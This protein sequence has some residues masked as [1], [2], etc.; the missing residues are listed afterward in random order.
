MNPIKAATLAVCLLLL[1]QAGCSSRS[2]D[3][4]QLIGTVRSDGSSTVFLLTEA[5]AEEFGHLHPRVRVSVGTSGTGGGFKKL[6]AGEIDL[7]NASRKI[8]DAERDACVAAGIEPIE[9][10]VAFDGLSVVVN[11]KNDWVES[12]T[13][14]QL[15][16]IWRP[17]S[18]IKKW[19]DLNPAWPDHDIHLFGP[20]TDSGT[21]DYFT[22]AICG[23]VGAS[24]SDYTASE[25]DNTLVTGVERDLYA[26]GYFGFAYYNQNREH[27]KLIPIDGGQGPVAP[28][29]ATI[30]DGTYRPLSRPLLTYVKKTS[31]ERPEIAAFVEFYLQQAATLS[32]EVGYVPLADATLSEQ[33]ATLKAQLGPTA[34]TGAASDTDSPGS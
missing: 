31:L 32:E 15:R 33:Q 2:H 25:D 16:E 21:F 28:S 24:R 23:Q 5:V 10:Q 12:L 19:R 13:T 18:G 1:V 26:L 34:P 22:E 8:R 6:A 27:L 29:P 3:A 9:L 17:D 20:G 7:C 30:R 11:P 4:G 14:E